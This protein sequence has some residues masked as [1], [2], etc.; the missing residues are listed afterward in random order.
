MHNVPAGATRKLIGAVL[1]KP[2]SGF[3]LGQAVDVL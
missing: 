1:R 2:Q 3:V